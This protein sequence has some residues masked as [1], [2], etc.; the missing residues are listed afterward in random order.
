MGRIALYDGDDVEIVYPD[1]LIRLRFNNEL[2]LSEFMKCFWDTQIIRNQIIAKS[3]TTNGTNKINQG[4]VK[5]ITFPCPP[6]DIQHQFLV[7]AQAY[8]SCLER[9]NNAKNDSHAL[10]SSL[11]SR[12]FTGELTA[13]WEATNAQQ[14]A[15][16]QKFYQR[17]PQLVILSFLKKKSTAS[18][19]KKPIQQS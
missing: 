8:F 18:N 5:S 10:F 15:A 9:E 2:V 13:E 17:L 3:N 6:I 1:T 19:A 11:L 4:N 16:K 14:I 12:A 7:K